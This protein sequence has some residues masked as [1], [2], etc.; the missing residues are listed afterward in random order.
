M[1]KGQLNKIIR[2]SDLDTDDIRVFNSTKENQIKRINEPDLGL[3]IA[4]SPKIIS[5]AIDAGYEAVTGLFEEGIIPSISESVLESLGDATIFSA[6]RE[7]LLGITGYNLTSGALCAF[8]RKKLA[9]IEEVI[10]KA[11]RIAILEHVENPTNLGAIFRSAAALNIDAVILS[12]DCTDPLYRRAIRVSMGNVFLVP[13]TFWGDTAKAWYESGM[14]R[15]SDMGYTTVAM[16]LS[17]DSVN[18]N[19]K[20]LMGHKKIAIIMGT[21]GEGLQSST[22]A[23][24]DYVVKIPMSHGVDSLNVA[25]ASAVAFWQLAVNTL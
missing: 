9:G 7:T 11:R 1:D 8:R 17:E 24:S 18:L 2:I 16:A 14:H 15:L 22:I 10:G 6:D 5:R 23:S 21:E 20:C 12:G 25:A 3:F 13:W 4:E 19:D